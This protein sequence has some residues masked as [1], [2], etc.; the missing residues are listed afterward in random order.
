MDANTGVLSIIDFKRPIHKCY[1]SIGVTDNVHTFTPTE[2]LVELTIFKVE[3]K[4]PETAPKFVIEPQKLLVHISEGEFEV[5][6]PAMMD[7]NK[8]DEI[9]FAI[10]KGQPWV[11]A[12]QDG[13]FVTLLFKMEEEMEPGEYSIRVK[14]SD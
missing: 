10:T 4:V 8:E 14:L 1:I 3:A 11:K 12:Y 5:E 13:N 7:I 6:L 2:P 9:S